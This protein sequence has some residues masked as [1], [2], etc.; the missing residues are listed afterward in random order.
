V[1][2]RDG[3]LIVNRVELGLLMGRHPDRITKFSAE[4]M[5]VLKTGGRGRESEYDAVECLAWERRRRVPSSTEQERTRYFKAMTDKV[6]QEIRTRAGV[7]IEA[8]EAAARWASMVTATRERLLALPPVAL[9]RH[10]I[11]PDAEEALIALVDDA[12]TELAQRGGHAE[13]A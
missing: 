5:P 12:L 4:G 1:T 3:R 11:T 7:L 9:Q 13:R 10:L 2:R 8:D 6:E